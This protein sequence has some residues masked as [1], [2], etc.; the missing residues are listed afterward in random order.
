[1]EAD[2]D[3]GVLVPR[4]DRGLGVKSIST[5]AAGLFQA[6]A[7]PGPLPA[8]VRCSPT[9]RLAES[10]VTL[11]LDNV[12]ELRHDKT[13]VSGVEAYTVLHGQRPTAL[14]ESTT[15]H[16]SHRAIQHAQMLDISEVGTLSAR[17]YFYGR[18]P[19]S[20]RWTQYFPPEQTIQRFLDLARLAAPSPSRL[21]RA[22]RI[23]EPQSVNGWLFWKAA[24]EP[25]RRTGRRSRFKLY[26]SPAP[27]CIWDVFA[28]TLPLLLNSSAT[29]FKIGQDV[30]GLLRPDK[31]VVYFE[32][33]PALQELAGQIS[34]RLAGTQSHGV[35]FTAALSGDG[36]LSWGIDPAHGT[37]ALPWQEQES[38]RLWIT[39]R[40][41]RSLLA[42]RN[43]TAATLEPWQFALHRLELDGIDSA[44]WTPFHPDWEF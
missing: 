16:L 19:A 31:F 34:R 18:F 11:L 22:A 17:M 43:S 28:E 27:Q 44:T 6:L 13:F 12:L 5:E 20:P 9:P 2:D 40:L 33:L 29:A 4:S 41:A 15:G 30:F 3:F 42:A 1:L 25:E 24:G 10:I 8:A 21:R 23:F 37:Q 7:R 26:I 14:P 39:N 32:T 38:W 35:P 36:L